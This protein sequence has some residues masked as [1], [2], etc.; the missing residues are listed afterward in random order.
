MLS[1]L[2]LNSVLKGGGAAL[3]LVPVGEAFDSVG[4]VLGPEELLDLG[5]V[6]DLGEA[7]GPDEVLDLGEALGLDEVLGP[8]EVLDLGEAL[9]PDEVLSLDG[10]DCPEE[11]VEGEPVVLLLPI[12]VNLEGWL[13][14]IY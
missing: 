5:E 12:S 1:S 13:H 4:E 8:D 7:L 11:L 6:L 3:V 9:G 14:S 2:Y 10:D